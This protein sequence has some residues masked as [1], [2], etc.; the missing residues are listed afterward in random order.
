L[1]RDPSLPL[2]SK[3]ARLFK[4]PRKARMANGRWQMVFLI[5]IGWTACADGGGF[6]LEMPVLF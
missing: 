6:C 5:F 4:Q 1:K 2:P 3:A